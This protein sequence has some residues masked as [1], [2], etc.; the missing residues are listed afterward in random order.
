MNLGIPGF[1]WNDLQDYARLRD[2]SD[3]FDRFLA[4]RGADQSSLIET[5]RH[6]GAFLVRL[7]DT[8]D[9]PIRERAARDAEVA[10]FKKE[11][12]TRRVVKVTAG[13]PPPADDETTRQ[14][15]AACR[16]PDPEL[17]VAREV[18]AL[19]DSSLKDKLDAASHW[20]ASE[21]KRGAFRGWLR[22]VLANHVRK[23]FRDRPAASRRT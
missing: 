2:L 19:L 11:F 15:S 6:L 1:T 5:S 20:A 23:F 13:A 4:E 16:Q 7:F 18:N 9:T 8:D 21:W 10:R 12:V 3:R 17:A 14:L 22:A